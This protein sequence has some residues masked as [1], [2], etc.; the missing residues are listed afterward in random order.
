MIVLWGPAQ[1]AVRFLLDTGCSVPRISTRITEK[2][3]IP[4]IRRHQAAPLQNCSGEEVKGVGMEYTKPLLLQHQKH[5]LQEVFEVA[6][7]EPEVDIFLPF[8]WIAKHPPQGAWDSGELR[9]SSPSC[10]ENCCHGA[11]PLLG[12]DPWRHLECGRME[13]GVTPSGQRI[14]L[15]GAVAHFFLAFLPHATTCFLV[16]LNK[17]PYLFLH[18]PPV[19]PY[20]LHAVRPPPPLSCPCCAPSAR[21]RPCPVLVAR[22]PL[23]VHRPCPVLI[24]R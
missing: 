24:A 11:C 3:D 9:F 6:P 16:S 17:E 14:S 1:Y 15:K 19:L 18:T 20:L 4:R 5:Y 2:Y 8:W 21:R 7:F 13:C 12:L 22:R 10:L 23:A